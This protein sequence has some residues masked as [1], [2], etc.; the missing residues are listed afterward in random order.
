MTVSLFERAAW[1]CQHYVQL[2]LLATYLIE[3]SLCH[4]GLR[5][6]PSP[7]SASTPRGSAGSAIDSRTVMPRPF[8]S[9]V[10]STDPISTADERPAQAQAPI[11]SPHVIP[12]PLPIPFLGELLEKSRLR[13]TDDGVNFTEQAAQ[14]L[15]VIMSQ[16]SQPQQDFF[17]KELEEQVQLRDFRSTR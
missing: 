14:Q 10:V 12:K 1:N 7:R 3:I 6:C 16:L 2:L 15:S 13:K 4:R 8:E 5:L 17:E 11:P 9:N